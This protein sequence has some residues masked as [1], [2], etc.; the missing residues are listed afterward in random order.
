MKRI[1]KI[2]KYLRKQLMSSLGIFLIVIIIS[3]YGL[4]YIYCSHIL[5]RLG[6]IIAFW[7]V[8]FS[9]MDWRDWVKK[10]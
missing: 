8:L 4:S 2:C 1:N 3:C 6:L 5:I 9:F 10:W 7:T